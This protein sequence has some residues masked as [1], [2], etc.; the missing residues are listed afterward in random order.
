MRSKRSN[1]PTPL[2]AWLRNSLDPLELAWA[3]S[4]ASGLHYFRREPQAAQEQAEA[5]IRLVDRAGVSVLGGDGNL[6]RGWALAMHGRGEEGI[7]QM[8]QGL[9]TWQAMGA[10]V[11]QPGF[12][13]MLAEAQGEAG[14]AE[15]GL[16]TLAE[17]V[18]SRC[19]N[20]RAV[21]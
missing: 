2:S 17:R 3:L 4:Y 14:Q 12:L 5:A 13:A 10:V 15:E 19:Q 16:R 21:L 18:C 8:Y 6:M 7:A 11:G 9:A 1:A 20:G